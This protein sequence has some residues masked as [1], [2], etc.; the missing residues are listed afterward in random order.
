MYISYLCLWNGRGFYRGYVL[1]RLLN[2]IEV[3]IFLNKFFL[4]WTWFLKMEITGSTTAS[5]HSG[6]G[7]APFTAHFSSCELA[8]RLE[9][10]CPTWLTGD[11]ELLD[12]PQASSSNQWFVLLPPPVH[13]CKFRLYLKMLTEEDLTITNMHAVKLTCRNY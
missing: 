10:F 8:T 4:I 12:V 9:Y 11:D 13:P 5:I 1:T 2:C 3:Q 7:N 6:F